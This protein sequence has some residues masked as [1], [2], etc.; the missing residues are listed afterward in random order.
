[1]GIERYRNLF[2]EI[3]HTFLNLEATYD[4]RS[5]YPSTGRFVVM[6]DSVRG[7]TVEITLK[8]FDRKE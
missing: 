7:H 3:K 5:Y 4:N 8:I 6:P 1:M 2:F